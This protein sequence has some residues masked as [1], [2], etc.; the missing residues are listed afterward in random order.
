MI[1]PYSPFFHLF[2]SPFFFTFFPRKVRR[3]PPVVP[4]RAGSRPQE[5]H[6]GCSP[7]RSTRKWEI[8]P[9]KKWEI[10]TIKLYQ[11]GRFREDIF[12]WDWVKDGF[13]VKV[14]PG[15]MWFLR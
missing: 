2:S 14:Q 15:I 13:L 12:H 4:W 7:G 6:S 9:Q 8:L 1:K 11:T 3:E 10:S 5:C